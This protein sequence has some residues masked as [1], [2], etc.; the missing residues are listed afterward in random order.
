MTSRAP[1][2]IVPA[3]VFTIIITIYIILG[4]KYTGDKK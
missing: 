2:S 4:K 1:I 3:F